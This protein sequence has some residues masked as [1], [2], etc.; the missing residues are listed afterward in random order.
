MSSEKP[1]TEFP[2]EKTDIESLQSP[3]TYPRDPRRNKCYALCALIF[4]ALVWNVVA[5][6]PLDKLLE[7]EHLCSQVEV[8]YPQKNAA[9]WKDLQD[10]IGTDAFAGKAVDWLAGA[11]KV[12]SESFDDM[13]P[14]GIDPRW[15]TF[16][17]F[18]EYLL[19]AFPLV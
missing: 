3:P 8:I 4:C 7:A 18:H 16:G 15:E 19:G 10:L 13:D 12:P 1:D 5:Y 9:L 14:V 6:E 2:K 11:V 17:L